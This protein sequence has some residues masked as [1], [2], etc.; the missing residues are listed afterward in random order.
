M[1]KL[2]VHH[3]SYHI[4]KLGKVN[5]DDLTQEEYFKKKALKLYHMVW[6]G[7]TKYL[8]TILMSLR[9]L[10]AVRMLLGLAGLC[11][12]GLNE[13]AGWDSMW[14][15]LRRKMASGPGVRLHALLFFG[16]ADL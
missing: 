9:W 5:L 1:T 14:S 3:S 12:M 8:R 16:V 4:L 11:C 2:E 7:T 15:H 6:S 10:P 13:W